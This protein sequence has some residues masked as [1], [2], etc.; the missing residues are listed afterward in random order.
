MSTGI[1]LSHFPFALALFLLLPVGKRST[2]TRLA[3]L[4]GAALLSIVPVDGLSLAEY[5]HSL[6]N[7]LSITSL[8]WLAWVAGATIGGVRAMSERQHLQLAFGF[9]S[10]ALLLYP[11]AMGLSMFDPYR[12][13]YAPSYLLAFVLAISLA[14]W[15][16]RNYFGAAL[17]TAAT[18]VFLLDFRSQDNFWDYLIDPLL[19]LYCLSVV[20]SYGLRRAW[21]NLQLPFAWN[22]PT[23]RSGSA[24]ENSRKRQICASVAN[25]CPKE[26]IKNT[27]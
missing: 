17:L 26:G 21:R 24:C 22:R 4:A 14:L 16:I 1:V 5:V 10:L 20:G 6:T 7:D 15:L 19:S 27:D 18:A 13:G 11:A 23:D 25:L 3:A 9:S 8:L 2:R 12:L